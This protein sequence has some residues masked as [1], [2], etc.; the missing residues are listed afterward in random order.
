MSIAF[1]ALMGSSFYLSQNLSSDRP[2][3]RD[4]AALPVLD[5]V[6]IIGGALGMRKAVKTHAEYA[7]KLRRRPA[8]PRHPH[9]HPVAAGSCASPLVPIHPLHL[10][11]STD[12][13]AICCCSAP[14]P[15][16]GVGPRPLPPPGTIGA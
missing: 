2:A 13:G 9:E 7:E 8:G 15:R 12:R 1:G 6:G 11:S 14:A 16:S 10:R 5:G 4:P 3:R